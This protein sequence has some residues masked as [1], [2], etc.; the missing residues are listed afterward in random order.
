MTPWFFVSPSFWCSPRDEGPAAKNTTSGAFTSNSGTSHR[1]EPSFPAVRVRGL[2]K[3]YGGP[4]NKKAL[5]SVSLELHA[6]RV[7]AILGHN[8]AGE[9]SGRMD[10][11][12]SGLT[13]VV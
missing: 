12:K 11:H 5:D 7:T 9:E 13:L 8:G 4:G 6:G 2:S 10:T 3:T 1:A